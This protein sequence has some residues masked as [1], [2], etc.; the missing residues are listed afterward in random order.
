METTIKNFAQYLIV[1]TGLAQSTAAGYCG[2]LMGFLAFLKGKGVAQWLSVDSSHVT[3]YVHM[4]R[5]KG[6][7]PA[8]ISRKLS[9]FRR[10]FRYLQKEKIIGADPIA[11]WD[12]PQRDELLPKVLSHDDIVRILERLQ[13][14]KGQRDVRDLA[15]LELLYASGLRVSELMRL[16]LRDVDCESGYLRCIGKGNKERIVPIGDM[17]REAIKNYLAVSRPAMVHN[18]AERALFINHRGKAMSRQWFWRMIRERA[19][20]AGITAV[21]SPHTFRHS[22]ATNLLAGGAGIRSVQ[23][24][25]GH[26]DVSTTQVY[27]HLTDQRLLEAYRKSHPR[28]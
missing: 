20:Q 13:P 10:F 12:H 17:A 11:Y 5:A 22:F 15:M 8:T 1:E 2:D 21:V 19:Q 24:L 27:T 9:A 18:P 16:S 7:K 23:E 25:L 4:L 28:A 3:T 14:P 26:S 6:V